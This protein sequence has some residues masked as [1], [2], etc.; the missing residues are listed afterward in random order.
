[1][2]QVLDFENDRSVDDRF[3][4]FVRRNANDGSKITRR[5]AQFVG[6]EGNASFVGAVCLDERDEPP[7]QFT[8]TGRYF[9]VPM[10]SELCRKA[11]HLVVCFQKQILQPVADNDVAE[12]IVLVAIGV[13]HDLKPI[14]HSFDHRFRQIEQRIFFQNAEKCVVESPRD[15]DEQVFRERAVLHAE[16]VRSVEYPDQCTRKQEH[17]RIGTYR[18]VVLID[19]C[20]GRAFAAEQDSSVFIAYDTVVERGEIGD[21]YGE[22][23]F[24]GGQERIFHVSYL[25]AWL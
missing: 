19:R 24:G 6:V 4:G 9:V 1:M 20:F 10:L 13:S 12:Q 8:L 5:Y 3:Y 16:I 23:F 14:S 15:F 2:E 25:F 21:S 7:S 22:W 18:S 11:L 17:E